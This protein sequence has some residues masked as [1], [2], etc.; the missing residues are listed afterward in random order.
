MMNE[1]WETYYNNA[2][3]D[4]ER[5]LEDLYDEL[6][7]LES[8]ECAEELE[9]VVNPNSWD[10]DDWKVEKASQI[11]RV[12]NAIKEMEDGFDKYSDEVKDSIAYEMQLDEY[13]YGEV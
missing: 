6:D 3:R 8:V 5:E 1:R 7:E 11:D 9:N 4:Y 13:R 2:M 12:K 10:Y